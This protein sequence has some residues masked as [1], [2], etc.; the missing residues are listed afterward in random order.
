MPLLLRIIAAARSTARALQPRRCMT[1]PPIAKANDVNPDQ[2][3][4]H[5]GSEPGQEQQH[6]RMDRQ[7]TG[8]GAGTSN[9]S[10]NQGR[11]QGAGQ[12]ASKRAKGKARGGQPR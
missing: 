9:K 5:L 2:G 11:Q 12:Q 1:K 6:E 7:N 3:D 8:N 4:H 10:K